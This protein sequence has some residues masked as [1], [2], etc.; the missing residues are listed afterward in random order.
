MTELPTALEN[1]T[2]R[3]AFGRVLWVLHQAAVEEAKQ[4]GKML[5]DLEGIRHEVRKCRSERDVEADG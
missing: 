2:P 1:C 3:T 4:Q 5:L